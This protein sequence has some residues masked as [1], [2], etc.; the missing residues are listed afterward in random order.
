MP[1]DQGLRLHHSQRLAPVEPARKPDQGEAGGVSDALRLDI[2]FAVEGE[3]FPRYCRCDDGGRRELIPRRGLLSIDEHA[4]NSE[5]EGHATVMDSVDRAVPRSGDDGHLLLH[6]H[7]GYDERNFC[8]L[9]RPPAV[10]ILAPSQLDVQQ[11]IS[12]KPSSSVAVAEASQAN[13]YRSNNHILSI[14]VVVSP[15]FICK[16]SMAEFLPSPTND[17]IVAPIVLP[18]LNVMTFPPWV[19]LIDDADR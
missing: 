9:G 3:L 6:G 10:L 7:A 17:F 16:L 4:G 2:P 11:V 15:S 12:S 18:S 8:L 19:A 14:A 5:L 13:T 1:A